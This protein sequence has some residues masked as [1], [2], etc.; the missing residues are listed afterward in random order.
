MTSSHT[1]AKLK[2]IVKAWLYHNSSLVYWQGLDSLAVPFLLKNMTDE[3]LAFASFNQFVDKFCHNFFLKE[4]CSVMNEYLAI[5]S[6]LLVFHD[7]E[8]ARHLSDINFKAELYAIPWFLTMFSHVLS[9]H[10][11]CHL[12]DTLILGSSYFPM[13][14]GVGILIST[15]SNLVG[16][17]FNQCI[18]NFSNFSE[19]DINQCLTNAISVY[20]RTPPSIAEQNYDKSIL[21]LRY[22]CEEERRFWNLPGRNQLK[23]N[24]LQQ[25]IC[26]RISCQDAFRIV[27]TQEICGGNKCMIK[28]CHSIKIYSLTF[29]QHMSI[30]KYLI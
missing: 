27:E 11:L 22:P 8:L 12:W 28:K 30:K 17:D 19:I 23:L 18:L 1:K 26:P 25:E 14:F 20:N 15:R 29:V 9:L 21:L 6:Q 7:P 24:E 5:F 3:A 10:T 4:N 2:R 13:C 16:N